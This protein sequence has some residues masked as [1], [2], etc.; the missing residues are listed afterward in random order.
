VT[1]ITATP[2]F[3]LASFTDGDVYVTEWAIPTPGRRVGLRLD[4]EGNLLV[5]L[6]PGPSDLQ[7]TWP[8]GKTHQEAT[9]LAWRHYERHAR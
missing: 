5:S 7:Y 3:K 8:R 9:K 6:N 2:K 1:I 4:G